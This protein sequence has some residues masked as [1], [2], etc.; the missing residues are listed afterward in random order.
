MA[1][2]RTYY[3]LKN[4]TVGMVAQLATYLLTFINRT[5]F[6]RFLDVVYLG[7]NG[8]FSNILTMLS[9]AELGIGAAIAFCLYK[10]LAENDQCIYE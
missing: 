9:L 4:T 10:P 1:K 6:V 2:S 7:C 8:L 3:S 5:I